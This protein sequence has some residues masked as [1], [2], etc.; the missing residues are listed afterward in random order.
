MS[1]TNDL[2]LGKKKK[3]ENTAN[4]SSKDF[5]RFEQLRDVAKISSQTRDDIK[6]SKKYRLRSILNFPSIV[7]Q[8]LPHGKMKLRKII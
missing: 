5:H 2:F 3:K 1:R 6:F 7:P 8:T 4:V